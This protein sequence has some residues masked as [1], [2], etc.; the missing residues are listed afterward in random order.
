MISKDMKEQLDSIDTSKI[1]ADKVKLVCQLTKELMGYSQSHDN[2]GVK[3]NY[4]HLINAL[5]SEDNLDVSSFGE[6]SKL[7]RDLY[8]NSRDYVNSLEDEIAFLTLLCFRIASGELED[9]ANK[10]SDL[11]SG[12]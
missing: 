4:E 11:V 9:N 8:V 7:V 10:F 3:F 5:I 6:L 1:P 2:T 12:N